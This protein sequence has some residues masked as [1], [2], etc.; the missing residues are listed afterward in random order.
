VRSHFEN[1]LPG[2]YYWDAADGLHHA[3]IVISGGYLLD[4]EDSV[5]CSGLRGIRPE[6]IFNGVPNCVRCWAAVLP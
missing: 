4:D 3:V 6:A 1:W 2:H 5:A